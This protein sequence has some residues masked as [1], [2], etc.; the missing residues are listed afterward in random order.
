MAGGADGEGKGSQVR[1]RSLEPS[2][3][4]GQLPDFGLEQ[5][6]ISKVEAEMAQARLLTRRSSAP[7]V[8]LRTLRS[9]ERAMAGRARNDDGTE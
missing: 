8:R 5:V 6:R 2:T 9:L 7:H 3:E 4:H 1:P